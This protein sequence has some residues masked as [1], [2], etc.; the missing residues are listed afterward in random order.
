[1]NAIGW[2]I[3]YATSQ[4]W[5]RQDRQGSAESGAVAITCNNVSVTGPPQQVECASRQCVP[6]TAG[7]RYGFFAREL[8]PD[9]QSLGRGGLA[10]L[11]YGQAGCAGAPLGSFDSERPSTRGAWNGVCGSAAA[12]AGTLSMAVRLVVEKPRQ[13]PRLT[14]LFDDVLVLA[15]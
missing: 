4:T 12:P 7:T 14:A 6:A 8:M 10:A 5:N 9:G 1:V 11:F 13:E 2:T 15:R 3:E